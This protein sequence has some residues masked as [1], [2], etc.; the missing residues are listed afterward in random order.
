MHLFFL[1][2]LASFPSCVFNVKQP[3]QTENI[4]PEFQSSEE[5]VLR[6]NLPFPT[7]GGNQLWADCHWFAGWR[8]QQHVWT[9][10]AR[11][12]DSGNVRRAWGS[13]QACEDALWAA[14]DSGDLKLCSERVAV[15]VHGLGRTRS[16]MSKIRN[17]LYESGWEVLDM[18][19]P[20]TRRSLSEHANQLG[21]LLNHLAED[22]AKQVDFVT[23]SLGGIVV[24]AAMAHEDVW[25]DRLQVGRLVM[26]APPSQGSAV[27]QALK[28]F[29]PFRAVMGEVGVQLSLEEMAQ[30]PEPTCK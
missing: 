9:G 29:V 27:A 7:A 19:Y 23:H 13:L 6:P 21:G 10:H 22:G 16:S 28:D 24:R 3:D 25:M 26:I 20:S 12:L 2:L 18:G 1:A 11:L 14:R 8:V 17:A 15:V 30:V 5:M 4:A